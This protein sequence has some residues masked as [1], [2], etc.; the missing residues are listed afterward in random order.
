MPER[1]TVVITLT[2]IDDEN[3]K[4]EAK[5]NFKQ[6]IS[7]TKRGPEARSMAIAYAMGMMTYAAAENRKMQKRRGK[8]EV[9]SPRM[10]LPPGTRNG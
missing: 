4:I 2:D 3:V 6:M 7:I 8:I 10:V 1:H 9:V 5:P